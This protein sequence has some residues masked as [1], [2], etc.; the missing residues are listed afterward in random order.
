MYIPL[1]LIYIYLCTILTSG[2]IAILKIS[3]I[4][5]YVE[6]VYISEA[7][8]GIFQHMHTAHISYI[9]LP[10]FCVSLSNFL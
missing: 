7:L 2:I 5:Y 6:T 3:L 10:L 1:C 9:Q 4:C 8:C